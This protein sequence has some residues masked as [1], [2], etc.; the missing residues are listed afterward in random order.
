MLTYPLH[1]QRKGENP[2]RAT[3]S[4]S[5]YSRSEAIEL[6]HDVR[7]RITSEPRDIDYS[8]NRYRLL[9]TAKEGMRHS[10]DLSDTHY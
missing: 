5:C 2:Q 8:A 1:V 7:G 6:Y 4:F 10:L 9:S 3:Y